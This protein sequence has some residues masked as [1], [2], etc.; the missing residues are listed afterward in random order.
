MRKFDA[1]LANAAATEQ[2]TKHAMP[3]IQD[4]DLVVL[5]D[6]AKGALPLSLLET[7]IA[8]AKAKGKMIIADPK[9]ADISVYSGVDLLT[10]NLA[11]LQNITAQTLRSIESDWRGSN[12][13]C[14]RLWHW[15]HSNHYERARYDA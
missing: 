5:S 3:A 12:R 6:Y 14:Q 2:F 11:E 7:I 13:A 15:Q 9:R 8:H 4:A 10:P 1:D